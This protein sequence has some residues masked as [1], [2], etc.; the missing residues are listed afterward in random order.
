MNK[1][2]AT[3]E[4][5][6]L[7]EAARTALA[8]GDVAKTEELCK[9]L[10]A[11]APD[12]GRAFAF[13]SQTALLRGR[14]DAALASADRAARLR[15]NDPLAHVM[16]AK[17]LLAAGDLGG[18]LGAARAA[19][20]LPHSPAPITE[21]IG[22]LFGLLG[23]HEEAYALLRSVIA[24]GP[25][26]PQALFNLAATER[27][28]GRLA[29]A[30]AH[31]EALIARTPDFALAWYLNADLRKQTPKRNHVEALRRRIAARPSAASDEVLFNYALAKECEDLGD[32]EGAFDAVEAGARLQR[33]LK[34][35]DSRAEIAEIDRIIATQTRAALALASRARLDDAPVFVV[36]LPR[37]GTTLIERIVGS[38]GAMTSV[39][40]TG[41]FGAARA[42][43][44][45]SS[46]GAIGAAYAKAIAEVHAPKGRVLDKT[47]KNYLHC[48]LIHAALPNARIVLVRRRPMDAGWAM[49][50]AHFQGGFDFT[51]DLA[52]I[53][54]YLGA[55]RRLTRHWR[56]IL[57]PEALMIVDYEEVV[58]DQVG[59][60]RRLIEFLGLPWDD[61]VL[62]FHESVAPSATASAVQ[63]RQPIYAS[64]VGRWKRH[65]QR[66]EPLRARLLR[67][68]EEAE[69]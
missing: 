67:D 28:L 50:K 55:F 54:D 40:E 56:A 30:E 20:A 18:A 10:I 6:S 48:G 12:D 33:G 41:A 42:R 46:P 39:G 63:V 14:P 35:S 32:D 57:P 27:M 29:D 52:A 21:A 43:A 60:S 66:L 61:E 22:A 51:Y 59:Q 45:A 8:R 25:P 69:L 15:P 68:F 26:T 13:L 62:R 17:A 49:Y 44:D 24:K 23:R 7:V 47:L 65:G 34:P 1:R 9:R 53:G 4:I 64:S 11:N 2:L 5:S 31:C 3:F 19:A 37:S 38:H 36:G 58:R 16:R